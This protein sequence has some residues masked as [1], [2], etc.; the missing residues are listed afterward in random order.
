MQ[1][2]TGPLLAGAMT[3]LAVPAAFAD[4]QGTGQ[5]A[6]WE[7]RIAVKP[8]ASKVVVPPGYKISIFA[9]G[10]DTPSSATVDKDDNLWVAISGKLLG[11]P[12]PIDD[13]HVK[14]FDKTGKLVKEI[15]KGIFKT[16]MNEIGY[17]ADND[18]VYIPEYG[19][20]IWE[21]KG[22]GGELK[23]I[24][25]D[26]PIGDHRNGGIT[27]K[28][29]FLYFA[30][31]FPSNTGFADP[32]NH[33]WPDIPNDPFWVKHND[34]LGTTPHDPVC[35]DITH[36]GLNVLSSDGRMTGALMPVGVAAKPGQVIK[37]QTP[38]GGSIMRVRI[39]GKGADGMYAHDKMEVYAFGFRNQ[40]GVAFG[41]KGTKWENALAISDNGANDLGHRRV[42]NGAE[43]LYIVTEKGQDAGFPDKE[44]FGFVTNKRFGWQS[45]NGA[46]VDRPYPGLYIGTKP[47]VP[48]TVPYRFQAHLQ[49]VRGVPL[50]A[51]NPNPNGYINPVLEWDSN[52]PI[53]GIAWSAKGFGADNNLFGAVYGILDTGPESLVPTWPAVLRVEFLEPTGVKWTQFARNIEPGPSAYQKK[54]NQGGL[55]RPNDVVFSNDGATMY[56]IDY[57]EVYTD[58][59]MPSP[60]YTVP[61]SGV[62]WAI[63]KG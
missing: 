36:T 15:G 2:W 7:K 46:P 24:V 8:D 27:C 60:F 58:F 50:I 29:G 54:D 49:G 31:G 57:G 19:E 5:S 51:A 53:D 62:V 32:D 11:G 33:G 23:Q 20:K 16:V 30:L 44:G 25:G 18:T 3:L 4:M 35:R 42:A 40:A 41:P 28:D 17:C 1:R 61:K 37:A 59:A 56:V 10:L 63:T 13:A 22:V 38:C 48:K 55:E 26:L 39:D 21:I 9:Q 52:N 6:G 12:D 43:K 14:V 45:Y 34:G 47:F